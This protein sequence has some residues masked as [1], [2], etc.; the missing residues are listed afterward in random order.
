MVSSEPKK[1]LSP[2]RIWARRA[3]WVV[4][5]LV[6]G[7]RFVFPPS[8]PPPPRPWDGPIAGPTPG[9]QR[10]GD[11]RGG[12]GWRRTRR[13]DPVPSLSAPLPTNLWRIQIEFTPADANLLR[14]YVWNGW[15]RGDPQVVE[16]PEVKATVREGHVV[17]TNVSVHLKGSAGSFRPFDDR[18]ALTLNFSKFAAGQKFHGWS[19]LSLNNSVQDSSFIGETLSREL[20]VLAGVPAPKATHATVVVDGRDLG[21]YVVTEGWGKPFLRKHFKDVQGNLYDGGFVQ[22]VDGLLTVVSGEKPDDRSD[23]DR[24]N[25]A[26][27]EP[28]R[29]ERWKRLEA[30]L[31]TERFLTHLALD[32]L[33]CNWDGYGINRNNYRVFQDRS[34]GKMVFM[35][36]G[37]DQV[38]GGGNRMNPQSSI[39]TPMRG[40]VAR[41]VMSTSEGRKRFRERLGTLLTNVL[42]E[43]RLTNRVYELA[44]TL[45]PTL[46]AYSPDLARAHDYEVEDLVHRIRDRIQSVS[47]QLNSPTPQPNAFDVSGAASLTRWEPRRSRQDGVPMTFERLEPEGGPK[48][49]VIRT[50]GGAGIGSW[51]TRVTLAAGHYRLVGRVR[52]SSPDPR[53]GVQLRLSG[54]RP[55]YVPL[56]GLDW[57]TLEFRFELEEELTE[58]ELVAEF[59]GASGEAQFDESSLRL[60][61]VH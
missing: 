11:R 38:F 49:L 58:M 7:L 47:E 12:Q 29:S 16:R 3:V 15:N 59:L 6:L 30:E 61:R 17:Y 46:A 60:E 14:G 52:S 10:E 32:V 25:A 28:D 51:R 2:A 20:F 39:Q 42:V 57:Q 43:A 56:R 22:D 19:K 33:I 37:L 23:I 35:P 4:F 45:R 26:A 8:S 36:H 50:E 1:Y 21:L 53:N 9:F 44:A 41:A 27:D 31:D 5:L 24:L 34:L 48:L 18:P 55:N 13:S 40:K 54:Y